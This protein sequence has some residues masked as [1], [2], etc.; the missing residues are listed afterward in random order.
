M[1][2]MVIP[3]QPRFPELLD[4]AP[5]ETAWIV[6]V[7]LLVSAVLTPISGRLGDMYGKRTVLLFLLGMVIAGSATAAVST[8]LGLVLL[9]RGLQG[10]GLAVI[11]LGVSILRDVLPASSLPSA[12]GLV[13]ASVGLGSSLAQPL[14]AFLAE[15]VDWHAVFWVGALVAATCVLLVLL[16]VPRSTNSTGG[17]FDIVGAAGLSTGLCALL[18]A[19]SRGNE[20]DV[21]VISGLVVGGAGVLIAWGWWELR[22]RDPL[23]DLRTTFQRP[24]LLTNVAS[25]GIGFVLFGG[26]IVFPR[27]L[28]QESGSGGVGLTAL[29]ASLVIVPSGIAAVVV[30]FLGGRLMTRVHPKWI[31]IAG[32]LCVASSYLVARVTEP[33]ALSIGLINAGA[34]VGAGFAFAAMP[35]LINRSVPQTQTG[36]AN[37]VNALMRSLGTSMSAAMLATVL[38]AHT[39][40]G[41]ADVIPQAAFESSFTIIFGLGMVIA[42]LSLFIPRARPV[43]GTGQS[44]PD[45]VL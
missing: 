25:I 21:G 22:L 37:G 26:N 41:G 28:Q 36:S 3:L 17:R 19:I 27:L 12:A 9:G 39:T 4:A 33:S 23:V 45:L 1:T 32:A 11:P 30:S 34:A 42:A 31:L 44:N 8:S 16:V 14:C 5:S 35:S 40:V 43:P 6:T 2:T 10:A 20:W 13:T 29:E 24:V 18:L 7:T 15:H 38:T